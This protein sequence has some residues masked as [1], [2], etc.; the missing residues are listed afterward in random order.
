MKPSDDECIQKFT[1]YC[2]CDRC[3]KIYEETMAHTGDIYMSYFCIG[4]HQMHF[5]IGKGEKFSEKVY[6][7]KRCIYCDKIISE[8]LWCSKKIIKPGSKEWKKYEV[9]L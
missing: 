4:A 9:V 3:M 7:T 5:G 8:N 1:K 2:G 6:K